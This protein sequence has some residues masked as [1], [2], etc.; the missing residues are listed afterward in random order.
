[1]SVLSNY[2]IYN[3]VRGQEIRILPFDP[4]SIQPASY[5]VHLG[6]SFV[7][8]ETEF[9]D[10]FPIDPL[11]NIP[12]GKYIEDIDHIVIRPKE[13][14]LAATLEI[15]G[16][17][18]QHVARV[19]GVSSLG[20]LGLA[21]HTTAGYID[22]GFHGQV[23]LELFNMAPYALKLTPGMRIAQF[24]FER[25]TG[26]SKGYTGR[27]QS[28]MGVTKSRYD[29]TDHIAEMDIEPKAEYL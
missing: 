17:D 5:D 29:S 23:T 21:V 10:E 8:Y 22:P 28:Q 15:L 24:A 11:K 25:L 18:N 1:M 19:E 2:H 12:T 14:L 13:F 26:P 27:Y 20:R 9:S 7:I 3:A 16:L 4:N 6:S